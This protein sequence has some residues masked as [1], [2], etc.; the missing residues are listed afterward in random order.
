M[1]VSGFRV[2]GFRLRVGGAEFGIWGLK[3]K[4]LKEG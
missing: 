4:I 2:K 1:E 3:S